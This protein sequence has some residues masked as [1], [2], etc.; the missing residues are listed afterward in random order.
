MAGTIKLE[1]LTLE[2]TVVDED[3]QIVM[4]PGILGEV[5]ILIGHTP[6]LTTLKLGT[7]HYN[8]VSG[9]ERFVYVSGGFIEVL[10]D[11]VIVLAESAERRCDID[12]ERAQAA[13][14]RSR[15]R[16]TGD[17][18][19]E[20]IDFERARAALERALYRLKIVETKTR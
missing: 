2:K 5:G 15:K 4:A 11:R 3:A 20:N 14:E 13:L 6:F 7:L 8:D 9:T 10:P 17:S 19:Q 12:K 18:D 16:L 1:V